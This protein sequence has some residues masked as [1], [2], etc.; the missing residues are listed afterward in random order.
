MENSH[1]INEQ[2]LLEICMANW[3]KL[4]IFFCIVSIA[5]ILSNVKFFIPD[6]IEG[7]QIFAKSGRMNYLLGSLIACIVGFVLGLALPYFTASEFRVTENCIYAKNLFFVSVKCRRCPRFVLQNF[8]LKEFRVLCLIGTGSKLLPIIL[9]QIDREECY[10]NA[11]SIVS[12][13]KRSKN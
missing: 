1:E 8:I 13:G 11:V 9:L 2:F 7:L 6:V 5:L 10:D 3:R 12:F 4:S